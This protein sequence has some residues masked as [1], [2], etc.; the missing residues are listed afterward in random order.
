M[1]VIVP[2]SL[3]LC[4][5]SFLVPYLGLFAALAALV[6]AG[7]SVTALVVGHV[8]WADIWSRGGAAFALLLAA[9][10]FFCGAAGA[11][12]LAQGE[13][14]KSPVSTTDAP[15]EPAPVEPAPEPVQPE[16]AP[17]PVLPEPAPVVEPEPIVQ[18]QNCKE[19][20]E[21]G[22]APLQQGQPGYEPKHDRDG[23]GWACD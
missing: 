4:V 14:A 8:M 5:A 1:K 3:L 19:M 23:D 2:L 18:Y 10:L 12:T 17:E 15:V 6:L 13:I 21:A 7:V 16:P 22:A 9:A 11:G 20:R